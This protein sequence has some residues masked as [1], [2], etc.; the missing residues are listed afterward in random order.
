MLRLDKEKDAWKGLK[1]A[2]RSVRVPF[3]DGASVWVAMS[4]TLILHK[5]HRMITPVLF[6]NKTR[7]IHILR[8]RNGVLVFELATPSSLSQTHGILDGDEGDRGWC[9]VLS[10][11]YCLTKS[12]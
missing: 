10:R 11:G 7:T 5:N 12:K 1:V 2:N 4:D 6:E 9:V 8:I 3:E